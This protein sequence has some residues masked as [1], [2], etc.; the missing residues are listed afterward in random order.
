MFC[1]TATRVISGLHDEYFARH[2]LLRSLIEQATFRR[3]G[4][5]WKVGRKRIRDRESDFFKLFAH[6]G[7]EQICAGSEDWQSNDNH[8]TFFETAENRTKRFVVEFSK[9]FDIFFQKR[10]I[11]PTVERRTE[12]RFG[13]D[14]VDGFFQPL[15]CCRQNWLA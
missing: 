5:F 8:A 7:V 1:K 3:E 15:A 9:L 6:F 10:R 4:G 14:D 11:F 13:H 12:I 2:M